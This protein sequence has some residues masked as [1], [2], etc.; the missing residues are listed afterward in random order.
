MSSGRFRQRSA[1]P[2]DAS[3]LTVRCT[4]K[5]LA[6]LKVRPES[7][8]ETS[9][10][11]LGD[12]YATV[13]PIRP[14]HLILLVNEGTRLAA[15][16]PA[17]EI[18]TLRKR[19]PHA[20]LEV[21]RELGAPTEIMEL[22]R[23]AMVEVRF[24][25]TASRSVLGTMNDFAFLMESEPVAGQARDLLA[26]AMILNRTPVSP[27][28][29]DRPE[30]AAHRL[31]GLDR[32]P[33]QQRT[34]SESILPTGARSSAYQLRVSLREVQ[35]E[36]WRRVQVRSY[37][38]LS[39]LHRILQTVM[40]WTDSHLHQFRFGDRVY[41]PHDPEFPACLDERKA[42]LADLLRAPGDRLDYDY[43]L[44]DG[45]QHDV[46]LEQVLE[47]APAAALPIVVEGRRACPPEDC[48][49]PSGY[50]KLLRVLANPRHPE[51]RDLVEWV[52]GSFDPETFDAKTVSRAIGSA[53]HP[54]AAKT[55]PTMR[56]PSKPVT[57]AT[58]AA[59][60]R[61]S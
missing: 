31:L 7:T 4:A 59:G 5:L 10:T 50:E 23:K 15:V 61:R 14:V 17:R 37:V 34:A 38:T 8:A 45:W 12:W 52:G 51:H 33:R 56:G 26:L 13:L 1:L 29:Y 18:S 22:E 60:R 32:G 46:V 58:R 39:K 28:D 21:L 3:V 2:G 11:R 53:W 43:D 27:L 40:G 9:T 20:I 6:R 55:D 35:P 19:I 16:L 24:D 57:T 41:G 42:I 48:G 36:V 49:G 25:R 47:L 30:D 54:P 44:G